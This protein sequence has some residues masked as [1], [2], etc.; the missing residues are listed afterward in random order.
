MASI[1][2]RFL[3]LSRQ[4]PSRTSSP[5][6]A[7]K[8]TPQWQRPFSTTS[9]QKEAKDAEPEK[10]AA[11]DATPQGETAA[12]LRALVDDLKSLDP[13]LIGEAIRKGKEGIPYTDP[14]TAR[15]DEEEWHL[16]EAPMRKVGYWADG[17]ESLGADED[18]YG[19]DLTSLGHGELEQHRELREYAR[20]IAWELPL[21][22]R[23]FVHIFRT[24]KIAKR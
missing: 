6:A 20:L 8:Y 2:R 22:S 15:Y 23:T 3:L 11:P 10:A 12:A 9:S 17:E 4:C 13:E 16:T 18:Y 21:L 14:H 5:L 1:S 19:D 7:P 24:F